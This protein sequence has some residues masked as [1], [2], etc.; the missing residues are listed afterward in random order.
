MIRYSFHLLLLFFLIKVLH[1]F[2]QAADKKIKLYLSKISFCLHSITSIISVMIDY[3][4]FKWGGW[5]LQP[6][7]PPHPPMLLTIRL[8][9]LTHIASSGFAF[10]LVYF[11]SFFFT[12]VALGYF[13]LIWSAAQSKKFDD[14]YSDYG[15]WLLLL[16]VVQASSK[17][18]PSLHCLEL[19]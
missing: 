3:F 11:F 7:P 6:R 14:H 15:V 5:Y 13:G 2:S 10:T 19:I 18:S 4:P 9:R 8:T 1:I 12:H 16:D 17:R